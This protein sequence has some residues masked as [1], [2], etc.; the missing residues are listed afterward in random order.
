METLDP[1][2]ALMLTAEL[3]SSPMHVAVVM[4]LSPPPGVQNLH[5]R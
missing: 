3:L 4:I 5:R 1:I 2:D